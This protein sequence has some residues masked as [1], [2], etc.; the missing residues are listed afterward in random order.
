MALNV[1]FHVIDNM[2][3]KNRKTTGYIN[4]MKAYGTKEDASCWILNGS[5][6][7]SVKRNSYLDQSADFFSNSCKLN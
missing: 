5:Q 2:Y 6:T 3:D 7:S 4:C 1:G